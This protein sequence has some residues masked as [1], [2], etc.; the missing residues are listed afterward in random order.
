[1]SVDEIDDDSNAHSREKNTNADALSR[2]DAAGDYMIRSQCSKEADRTLGV[3]AEIDE[4]AYE[5]N[6]RK[7]TWH[8]PGSSFAQDGLTADWIMNTM[9]IHP[10]IPLILPS[11]KKAKAMIARAIILLPAWRNQIWSILLEETMSQYFVWRNSKTVLIL[12]AGLMR[13]GAVLHP[14]GNRAATL[15]WK[16]KL[17]KNGGAEASG[18]AEFQTGS[19]P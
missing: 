9:L 7:D 8:G 3:T 4:F 2:L 1:M 19:F 18:S 10:P 12:G 14:V 15:N 13:T 5:G 11:L 17:E 16:E 6:K